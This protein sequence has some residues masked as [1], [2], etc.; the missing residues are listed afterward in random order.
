MK[1]LILIIKRIISL[2]GA[3]NKF[4]LVNDTHAY[5]C[6]LHI[7]DKTVSDSIITRLELVSASTLVCHCD[8]ERAFEAKVLSV[9]EINAPQVIVFVYEVAASFG[10]KVET[11]LSIHVDLNCQGVDTIERTLQ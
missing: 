4:N 1:F 8:V 2:H 3:S 11:C 5:I 9:I 6:I 7:K 10:H